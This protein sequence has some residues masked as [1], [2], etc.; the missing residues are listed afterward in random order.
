MKTKLITLSAICVLLI[1]KN[2]YGQDVDSINEFSSNK[3]MI[4]IVANDVKETIDFYTQVIGMKKVAEFTVDEKFGIKSGLSGG[5]SI[6]ISVLILNDS[7]D[8]AVIKVLGRNKKT[9]SSKGKF[10]QDNT[11]VQYLTLSVISMKPIIKRIKEHNIKLLG[12]SPV[13]MG[14]DSQL[15]LIQDPN[16]IFIEI[17]GKK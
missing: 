9:N 14:E 4:G 13:S 17:M 3:I 8:A 12:E 16:G 5:N 15:L 2:I 10:I 6:D 11:G 7:K 1:S